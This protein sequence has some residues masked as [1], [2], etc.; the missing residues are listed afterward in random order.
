MAGCPP[1]RPLSADVAMAFEPPRL[2]E[3]PRLVVEARLHSLLI[4]RSW[5]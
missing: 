3:C 4:A 2:G 1:F 5:S